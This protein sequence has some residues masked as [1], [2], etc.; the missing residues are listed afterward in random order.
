MPGPDSTLHEREAK[1]VAPIDLPLPDFDGVVKGT[2]ATPLP[3]RRLDATYYDTG[4]LRLARW[5][6]TLRYRRGE[7]GPP[8]TLKLPD[9]SST[10]VLARREL[11]FDGAAASVP[12][13][14][15]DLVRAYVRTLPLAPVA[16]LVTSR[17]PL[18]I[19]GRDG[20]ALGEI[21]DDVV[22]VSQG[23]RCTGRFREIGVEVDPGAG[24]RTGRR[25]LGAAVARLV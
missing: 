10:P 4:D 21:V 3:V 2:T 16:R 14:A 19:R 6:I 15:G 23:H 18:E 7:P 13:A 24:R 17:A 20:Q 8:W 12:E 22:S 9:R 25:L 1:L 11:S 5:G